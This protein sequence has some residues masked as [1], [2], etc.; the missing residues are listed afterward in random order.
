VLNSYVDYFEVLNG[1]ELINMMKDELKI[2][3][4]NKPNIYINQ[5]K[6]LNIEEQFLDN[7]QYVIL[8]CGTCYNRIGVFDSQDKKYIIFNSI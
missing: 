2:L 8:K 3:D 7:C 6:Q 1:K 4:N 5:L